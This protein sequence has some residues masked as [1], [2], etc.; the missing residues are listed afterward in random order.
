MMMMGV[1][2]MMMKMKL[3]MEAVQLHVIRRSHV[4]S[5]SLAVLK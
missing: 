2:M 3:M 4:P 5:C 1:K